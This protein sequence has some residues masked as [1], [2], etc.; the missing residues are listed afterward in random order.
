MRLYRGI[1]LGANNGAYVITD[2]NHHKL[3]SKRLPNS[4]SIAL[5]ALESFRDDWEIVV[6]ED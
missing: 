2:E 3:F 6:I 1:N 5:D 4:L